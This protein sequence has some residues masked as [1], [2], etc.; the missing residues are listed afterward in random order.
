MVVSAGT[1]IPAGG[2]TALFADAGLLATVA[3]TPASREGGADGAA[4]EAFTAGHM[5]VLP[6]LGRRGVRGPHRRLRRRTD[7]GSPNALSPSRLS[8]GLASPW[9]K[10]MPVED[11]VAA[12][13]GDLRA[14]G[15]HEVGDS[16]E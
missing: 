16:W 7:S 11:W 6:D 14:L 1:V 3:N 10:P 2:V 8:S 12:H 9:F 4:Q 15:Q 13:R 5:I